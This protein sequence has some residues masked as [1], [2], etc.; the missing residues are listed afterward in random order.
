[1]DCIYDCHRKGTAFAFPWQQ[2]LLFSKNTKKTVSRKKGITRRNFL[3]ILGSSIFLLGFGKKK[4]SS[5][6]GITGNVIRPPGALKEK[7]FL[8]RCVRCGNCMKVCIT[9]G[10]Q[11]V[12]FESGLQGIWTPQLVPEIGYCEYNCTL[13]GN[14]C[15]TGAISRLALKD[16]KNTKLGIARVNRSTCIAW[17][18]EKECIV[19][20]EHCPVPDKAIKVIEQKVHG[21]KIYKPY[22]DVNLCIGCGICQ[23][24]CPVRP[25]RA[26]IVYPEQATRA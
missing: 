22:V 19:C 8:D 7:D 20:E 3:L 13:C 24:K 23:H 6:N 5:D 16:K 17:K 14:V 10:L 26:I 25:M 9:N 12:M 2:G 4:V 18:D 21:K 1:M 15:P 11:P